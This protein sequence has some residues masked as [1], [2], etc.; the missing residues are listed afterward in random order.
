[1]GNLVIL[2][3]GHTLNLLRLLLRLLRN[4]L[5]QV[6]NR[7]L[8][9]CSLSL[10][11][12]E[13]LVPLVQ[14]SLKVVDVVLHNGQLILSMLQL[15]TSVIKEVGLEIMTTIGDHQLI[16]QLLGMHLK[17]EV[18]LKNLLVALLNVPDEVVLGR[19][20]VVILLQA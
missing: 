12:L 3:T 16:V 10:T 19:R 1:M 2:H 17:M 11:R 7:I 18:L 8:Q 20:L 13:L 9:L 14:L 6:L 15:C 5:L 4:Q